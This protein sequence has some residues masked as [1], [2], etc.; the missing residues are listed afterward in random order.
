VQEAFASLTAYGDRVTAVPVDLPIGLL[1]AAMADV[2]ADVTSSHPK[3][4]IVQVLRAVVALACADRV[5]TH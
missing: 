5:A 2:G 4:V 1:T 3:T